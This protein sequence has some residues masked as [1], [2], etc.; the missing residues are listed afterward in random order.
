MT[1]LIF[2][3]ALH[4]QRRLVT[5]LV[6]SVLVCTA[7]IG[8]RQWQGLEALELAAYDWCLN[9]QKVTSATPSPIVVIAVSEDDLR[10]Q[11]GWPLRDEIIAQALRLLEQQRSR[12]IGLDMFRDLP[13]PPGTD[14]LADV[15]KRNSN[16][17]VVTQASGGTQSRVP[18]PQAVAGTDQVG[19][20]DVTVDRDGV[21]RRGLL[22]LEDGNTTLSSFALQVALGYL[23]R[24]GI[25][26]QPGYTDP[27]QL[28]LGE[29]T[30]PPLESDDGGYV[31]VDAH[32]YQ[33]L[34]DFQRAATFFTT[35]SL[36]S[37]VTG[38]VPSAAL[39]D[40]IVLLGIT[41]ESVK[42]FFVIPYRSLHQPRQRI[43]G[44][45]LQA[46]MVDQ[47][48]RFARQGTTPIVTSRETQEW[49]W[50]A[51][52]SLFGGVLAIR[53][54]SPFWFFFVVGSGIV[55]LAAMGYGAFLYRWW[56]PVVPAVLGWSLSAIVVRI[57]CV[58]WQMED[59]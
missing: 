33:F 5:M 27:Q 20:A 19:F 24:E 11:G 26:R 7:V 47:L 8:L 57:L 25:V 58:P 21:V 49:G 52:W 37:L 29:V 4:E 13:V 45:V 38:E 59:V 10:R 48:L 36:T 44:V 35:F 28:R 39:R 18:P 53:F 40:Q 16:I 30:I 56:I 23:Q 34:L 17:V 31:A 1:G 51:L 6:A 54:A 14:M 43:P 9:H 55:A 32:G 15:L 2:L 3:S 46:Y 50:V 12:V 22:F 42:D 41:A